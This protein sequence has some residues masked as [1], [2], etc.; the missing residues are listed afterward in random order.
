[1]N[2]SIYSY[3]SIELLLILSILKLSVDQEYKSRINIHPLCTQTPT[4]NSN[5]WK[6]THTPL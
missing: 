2:I 4:L 1:M 5:A 3:N 6:Y